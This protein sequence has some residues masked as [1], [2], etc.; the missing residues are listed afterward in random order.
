MMELLFAEGRRPGPVSGADAEKALLSAV[1]AQHELAGLTTAAVLETFGKVHHRLATRG[2]PLYEPLRRAGLP[3]FLSFIHPDNLAKLLAENLPRKH[4][5]P[6][7]AVGHWIAGN[8]PILG[9]ISTTLSLLTRNA[10]LVKLPSQAPDTVTPFLK[11]FEDSGSGEAGRQILNACAVVRFEHTDAGANQLLADMSD[12][13]VVWGTAEAVT[14]VQNLHSTSKS[15]VSTLA[16]GPKISAYFIDPQLL[17]P[18]DYSAIV[19]DTAL[20]QQL[21]CTSPHAIFVLGDTAAAQK[22]GESLIREWESMRA[23]GQLEPHGFYQTSRVL[24]YRARLAFQGW[25]VLAAEGSYA[26]VA[27]SPGP[28][29]FTAWGYR[30]LSCIPVSGAEQVLSL[31]PDNSQ[32]LGCRIRGIELAQLLRLPAGRRLCRIA[33]L[34]RMH[35]F[36]LPWDGMNVLERM[37]S[38]LSVELK[39]DPL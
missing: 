27:V 36:V 15:G 26:T 37:V 34:G 13:R 32:T 16:F 6:L 11:T 7:G 23:S 33:P 18:S 29:Q 4:W 2:H 39:E 25:R 3:F 10:T 22:V 1:A 38:H 24:E 9:M 19:R 5:R 28:R 17:S 12:L 35:D 30:T 21:A 14:A 20:F 8:V 31:L